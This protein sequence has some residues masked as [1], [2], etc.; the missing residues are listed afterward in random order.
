LDKEVEKILK[1]V[2]E[3]KGVGISGQKDSL[4]VRED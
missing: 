2:K 4:K 3:A 1:V